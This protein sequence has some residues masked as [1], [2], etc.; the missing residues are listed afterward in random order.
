[1]PRSVSPSPVTVRPASAAE[2]AELHTMIIEI[3]THEDTR[4]AVRVT[5][6][7]L[8]E[9]LR[10]PNVI[11]L[12]AECEGELVGYVS[13]IRQLNLWCGGDVLALDDLYVRPGHRDR[14]IGHELM[15]ALAGTVSVD[16]PLI[17]WEVLADNH[18]AQ[19]FY[20]R[21]GANLRTK[22]IATWPAAV[23]TRPP[24]RTEDTVAQATVAAPT[25]R[26]TGRLRR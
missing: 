4:D 8:A 5:I 10:H 11:V 24:G 15:R 20:R 1:M 2:A 13:A 18:A 19:R 17:R 7:Q 14:G 16:R 9:L 26:V 22:I 6:D 25:N 12:F 3:A 21:L 23:Y